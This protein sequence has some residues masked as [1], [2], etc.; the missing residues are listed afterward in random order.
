[1]YYE[2]EDG[3]KPPLG[4]WF[5]FNGVR[6][7]VICETI[8]VDRRRDRW[9]F[10]RS[11]NLVETLRLLVAGLPN[12]PS[13]V[14]CNVQYKITG[15]DIQKSDRVWIKTESVDAIRDILKVDEDAVATTIHLGMYVPDD[16]TPDRHV[17]TVLSGRLSFHQPDMYPPLAMYSVDS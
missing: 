6:I 11:K 16:Y 3:D 13:Q 5:L 15:P 4:W 12:D 10:K 9:E 17:R 14:R 2:R 8:T 7:V 1:M